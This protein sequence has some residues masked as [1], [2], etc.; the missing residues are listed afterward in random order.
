MVVL[1]TSLSAFGS[2]P[3]W[4]GVGTLAG[5]Y[6]IF[7]FGLQL[8]VGFTGLVNLG[9]AGFMLLGAYTMALLVVDVG[10]PL[11]AGTLAAIVICMLA[12][13]LVGIPSLRLRADYFALV[14]LAFAETIRYVATN[15]SLT[16]GDSGYL[17]Y[18]ESW[19]KVSDWIQQQLTT[20][21][22]GGEPQMPL[23]V[24]TWVVVGLLL[25]ALVVLQRTP[26]GR[27]LRAIREDE[28][29]TRALGKNVLSF[30]LQSLAIAAGLAAIAGCLLTLNLSFLAPGEFD[31]SY[32]FAGYAMLTLGGLARYSGVVLGSILLWIMLEATR[33]LDLPISAEKVASLRFMIVGL[34]LILFMLY[35]PQGILGN[36]EEMVLG[37]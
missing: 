22:L 17:F 13:V 30:K 32:T 29:A 16:G 23:L 10:W 21:G 14:T 2:A 24:V 11:W 34:I 33:F 25:A 18:S 3:F 4:I 36:R 12:G 27:V 37:D 20:V 19:E 35:R 5:I 8:N 15:I 26:W 7:T 28:D 6:C 1:A 9:Q 31:S